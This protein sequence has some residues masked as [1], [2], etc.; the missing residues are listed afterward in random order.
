MRLNVKVS[1]NA[2]NERLVQ[3]EGMSRVYLATTRNDPNPNKA[4][5]K[6][7]AAHFYVKK[8]MVKIITGADKR[9]KLI[10]VMKG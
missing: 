4:L 3:E 1:L 9:D 10:N 7:L 8:N 5:I 2:K 6:F